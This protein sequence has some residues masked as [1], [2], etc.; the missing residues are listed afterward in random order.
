[1]GCRGAP[2][3][4]SGGQE[5]VSGRVKSKLIGRCH[6][7]MTEKIMIEKGK[8]RGRLSSS[9]IEIWLVFG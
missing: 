3:S 7:L 8:M 2:T 1:M 9:G 5:K 4:N 6:I